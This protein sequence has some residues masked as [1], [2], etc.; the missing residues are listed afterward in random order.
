M[1]PKKENGTIVAESGGKTDDTS[2]DGDM[3][4]E[5]IPDDLWHSSFF[6]RCLFLCDLDTTVTSRVEENNESVDGSES[7]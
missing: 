1:I 4:K 2:Q 5:N 6:F 3:S 7:Q